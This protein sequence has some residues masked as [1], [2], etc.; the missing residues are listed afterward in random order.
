[1]K[2]I[3]IL[4]FTFIIVSIS[5]GQYDTLRCDFTVKDTLKYVWSK[6]S[7]P[8]SLSMNTIND[9]SSGVPDDGYKAYG[10]LFEAPDTVA[11]EG[12]C[13]YAYMY[14]GVEDTAIVKIYQTNMAGTLDSLIDSTSVSIPLK[15][16]YAGDLYSDSIKICVD[17]DTTHY[18]LGDYVITLE[19]N[20]SSDMYLV[21][22][23]IG[24]GNQEDLSFSYYYWDSNHTYDGWYRNYS[25]FG[26]A[27]D[28]D[29]IIEPIVSYGLT[30]QHLINKNS[31]CFGDTLQISSS[32][33]YNDSLMYNRMYNPNYANYADTTGF[34]YIYGD[35]TITTD[36]S[37]VYALSGAYNAL[38][39]GATNFSGWTFND[40]NAFCS[41]YATAYQFNINLGNDTIVCN[42]SLILSGGQYF[43]S[44]LWN[45]SDTTSLLT[46]YSDSLPNGVNEFSLITSFQ[47][48]ESYDT[49]L[50][51]ANE[52]SV[53][54]GNDTTLC[55][56][57]QLTIGGDV[58]GDYS[59]SSGQLTDSILVGPFNA[60]D[61]LFYDVEV[62]FNGCIG[63]DT[64]LVF[65]DN[66]LGV[67]EY[68]KNISIYPNPATEYIVISDIFN[69]TAMLSVTD[70]SGKQIIYKKVSEGT[71]IDV[72][73]LNSGGYILNFK[74]DKINYQQ[75]LQ[76]IK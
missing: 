42:D 38:F 57:Q 75:I 67:K 13:F 35:D 49:I 20:S 48:C 40:Y 9:A 27:W 29:V 74:S 5:W 17:L 31:G 30:T 2:N 6:T 46:I 7:S 68:T 60:S 18:L 8:A 12:F 43:D 14:S 62:D 39:T 26:S 51:T 59:W 69:H 58:P 55:L 36:T 45:T 76:I 11:L 16:N 25:I 22:D 63:R 1:M 72:S 70:L 41:Y 53:N 65:I 32:I 66:C 56:N 61:S 34:I 50:V 64:I 52:L 24:D 44:Y 71:K 19:N 21:R 4:I 54:L 28:F 73:D 37:H 33:E 23:Q 47:G 10:Q 15:L 3:L